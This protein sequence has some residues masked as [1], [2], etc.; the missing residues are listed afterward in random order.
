MQIFR[1]KHDYNLGLWVKDHPEP[2]IDVCAGSAK[3]AAERACGTPLRNEGRP[4][5]YRA[6]VWPS[7]GVRRAT[8]ISHF[9]CS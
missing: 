3:E 1:V 9:Y 7:G 5:E 6:K 4:G 8:E 2:T